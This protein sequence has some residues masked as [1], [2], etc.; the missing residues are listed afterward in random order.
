M[1]IPIPSR[2]GLRQCVMLVQ[3]VVLFAT[4]YVLDSAHHRDN[5]PPG[6]IRAPATSTVRLEDALA[7]SSTIAERSGVA[8][9][10]ARR[11]VLDSISQGGFRL[12]GP[13]TVDLNRV[14]EIIPAR[15]PIAATN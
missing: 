10:Y 5:A 1:K 6:G 14:D 4:A 12:E 3:L 13:A 2:S 7:S 15:A 8:E 9:L 11:V